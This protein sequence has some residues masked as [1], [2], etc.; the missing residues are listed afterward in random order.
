MRLFTAPNANQR[1]APIDHGRTAMHPQLGE[2]APQMRGNGPLANM[3]MVSN[4]FVGPSGCHQRG[5]LNL[6]FGQQGS[7]FLG[8]LRCWVQPQH[9]VRLAVYLTVADTN[10]SRDTARG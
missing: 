5:N 1:C 3:E 4:L 2:N 10:G 8:Y 7:Q 9:R 6:T